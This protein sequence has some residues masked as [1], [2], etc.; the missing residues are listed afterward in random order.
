MAWLVRALEMVAMA[1]V[2]AVAE[3]LADIIGQRV[4]AAWA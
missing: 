2:S 4:R 1:V 3:A